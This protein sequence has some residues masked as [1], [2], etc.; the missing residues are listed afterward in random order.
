VGQ[1]FGTRPIFARFYTRMFGPALERAGV[2]E[3]L[4]HYQCDAV[5]VAFGDPRL[6]R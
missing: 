5:A 2:T 1:D 3:N 6:E 4:P